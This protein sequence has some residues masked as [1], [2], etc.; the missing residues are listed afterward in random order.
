MINVSDVC[1]MFCNRCK[2]DT[3]NGSSLCF[4]IC[5][6]AAYAYTLSTV[7]SLQFR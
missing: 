6:T 3:G 2:M 4:H 7:F 1:Y 5:S